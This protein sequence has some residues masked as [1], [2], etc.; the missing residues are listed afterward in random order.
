MPVHLLYLPNPMSWWISVLARGTFQ[1][2]CK[3]LTRP[4]VTPE[5]D[6]HDDR[7]T[8]QQRMVA[9]LEVLAPAEGYNLTALPDVRFLRSN[10]P[11]SR[12]PVLYDPGIVIV[13]QGRK[14]GYWGD[15]TYLYD[16]RHYLAVAVPVP[17]TMGT[18]ASAGEP[19]LA[20]Y[21]N[22]DFKLAADMMLQLNDEPTAEPK[23]M[24]ASPMEP[25]LNQSVLR[26]LE[27]L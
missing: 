11:L 24:Y 13:C 1:A 14:R 19:L 7:T 3:K 18:D 21:F 6:E 5:R 17:F 9:L 20:I 8:A 15:A 23:G 16:A 25:R 2:G 10:R 4:D 26:L 12:T 22:L 27:A